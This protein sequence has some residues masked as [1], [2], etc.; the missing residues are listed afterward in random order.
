LKRDP[1]ESENLVQGPACTVRF[2]KFDPESVEKILGVDVGKATCMR[3]TVSGGSNSSGGGGGGV[4]ILRGGGGG[5]GV[6]REMRLMYRNRNRISGESV[7]KGGG[8]YEEGSSALD[9]GERVA[10]GEDVVTDRETDRYIQYQTG[11][12]VGRETGRE[13]ERGMIVEHQHSNLTHSRSLSLSLPRT[14]F[15]LPPP[16]NV[17]ECNIAYRKALVLKISAMMKNLSVFA[18]YGNVPHT[19]LMEEIKAAEGRTGGQR[20]RDLA[21]LVTCE[22]P[23][24]SDLKGLKYEYAAGDVTHSC[25]CYCYCY[26]HTYMLVVL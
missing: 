4:G 22:T 2:D 10:L 6:E 21:S 8:E 20:D 9:A 23:L 3:A 13:I 15:A 26:I 12:E 11:R 5:G 24:A 19:H 14:L 7:G 17:E 1:L 16:L 25:Y 18:L